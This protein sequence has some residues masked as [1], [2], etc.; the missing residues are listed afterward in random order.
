MHLKKN[1]ETTTK[2]H[3]K[4]V[5]M[6]PVSPEGFCYKKT[7]KQKNNQTSKQ[8]KKKPTNNNKK[9]KKNVKFLKC[10]FDAGN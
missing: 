3:A 7:N 10:N 6:W 1:N 5:R 8:T 4:Y 2:A 9:N